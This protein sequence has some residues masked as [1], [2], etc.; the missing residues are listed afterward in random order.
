MCQE[1]VSGRVP[2]WGPPLGERGDV[3]TPLY[4]LTSGAWVTKPWARRGLAPLGP[5]KALALEAVQSRI[6]RSL[7]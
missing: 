4:L 5:E 2:L 1:G 6:E 3:A 7:L